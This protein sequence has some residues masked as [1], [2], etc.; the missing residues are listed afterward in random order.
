MRRGH[1]IMKTSRAQRF[2]ATLACCLAAGPVGA[3][4]AQAQSEESELPPALGE[5]EAAP[6]PPPEKPFLVPDVPPSFADQTQVKERWFT[7][8]P[9]AAAVFDYTA[10]TQD[11]ASLSQVGRQEDQWQVRDL[12]LM[13]R[14]TIGTDYKVNYFVAGVYKGFDSDPDRTW[15]LVD[16][17][18]A[19]PLGG[20]ATKLIVGKTKETF[21]YEMVGDSANLPQ[22]ERVLSPF[23][24]SRNVG[25]K[26]SHVFGDNQR[27]TLSGGVFNDWWTKGESLESS[28]TD[29]SA[30]L[31]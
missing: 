1:A 27:M 22:Q 4:N 16:L 10:F 21:D 28:G 18:F 30:R 9:G 2:L 11:A 5:F 20:P 25:A 29:V 8:K 19:F 14:G 24:V 26:L 3:L 6:L 23:F 7:L 31:T 15:E 12:R 17:W 13:L